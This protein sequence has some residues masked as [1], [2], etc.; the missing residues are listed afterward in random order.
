MNITELFQDL[1]FGELATLSLAQDGNGLITD[2]G[3]ERIIRFAND[4]LYK[5]YSRFILKEKDLLLEMVAGVTNYQLIL[6]FAASQAGI[7]GEVTLYIK[8]LIWEP[9]QDDVIRI[10][11]VFGNCGEEL[12]LNNDSNFYSA[13]TP[14]ANVLQITYGQPGDGVSVGY[15][16]KHPLLTLADLTQE[17]EL[18][19]VLWPALRQWIASRAFGQMQTQEAQGM[20]ANFEQKFEASC[21][22]VV[23]LDLVYS[24]TS[25]TNERFHLN[26]WI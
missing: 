13:F 24:S 4:G 5:L 8:D 10:L 26:G 25:Q 22:E 18:P 1:S 2:A 9:F 7:S 11:K 23:S 21:A 15:Q 16:A 14:Q 17:L 19:E 12:P 20:A 6:K 3:K